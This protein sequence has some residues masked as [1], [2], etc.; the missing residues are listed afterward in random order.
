[1]RSLVVYESWFGN[2]K[3]IA[4]E[5]AEALEE[6]GEVELVSVDAPV[7]ELGG[8]DLLVIGAPTHI[9]G[10]SSRRSRH[11]AL[12]QGGQGE[13][14]IGVRGFIDRLPNGACGPRV[15]AFDTR[16]DKPVWLVGSAARGIARRLRERG[17]LLAAEPES[18]FVQGTPGPLAAGELDRAGEWG[19]A[20]ASGVM[21]PAA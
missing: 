14:G 4:E 19:K 9:H 5:V 20:V 15:A 12:D 10:V 13:V 1:M 16:A 2:T 7:P 11:G 8:F 17:Y 18:F 3:R 21:S 6:E